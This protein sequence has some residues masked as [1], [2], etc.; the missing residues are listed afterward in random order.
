M[1]MGIGGQERGRRASEARQM[2]RKENEYSHILPNQF[3]FFS[4][5]IIILVVVVVVV[6]VVE[7]FVIV[8]VIDAI[9]AIARRLHLKDENA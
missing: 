2:G 6:V 1:R 4:F 5:L 3:H 7:V 9:V 8:F